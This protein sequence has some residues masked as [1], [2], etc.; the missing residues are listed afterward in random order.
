M[1]QPKVT[2]WM[3]GCKNKT[4]TYVSKKP[5]SDLNT[6]RLKVRGWK[7]ILHANEK[8]NKAGV[9]MPI[10]DKKMLK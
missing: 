6:Y 2:D 1:L 10:S 7:N 9:A 8:Q 4:R 5:T 3:N